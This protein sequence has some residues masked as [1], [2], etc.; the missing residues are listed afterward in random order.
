MF[1]TQKKL[2]YFVKGLASFSAMFVNIKKGFNKFDS[3]GC[4][5]KDWKMVSQDIQSAMKKF[6]EEHAKK[7]LSSK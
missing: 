7:K 5:N 6:E 2:Q 4:L 3:A 1:V